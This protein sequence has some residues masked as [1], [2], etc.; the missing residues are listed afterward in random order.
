MRA[1]LTRQTG[2]RIQRLYERRGAIVLRGINGLEAREH[3][4][5]TGRATAS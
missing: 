3:G 1:P 2:R 4:E 5:G